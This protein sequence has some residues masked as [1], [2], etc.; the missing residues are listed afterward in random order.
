MKIKPQ[1]YAQL[2]VEGLNSDSDI[3]KIAENLWHTLQKNKQYRDLPKILELID[4]E[5]A[6][7]NNLT[8][9][10]VYSEKELAG[11]EI[12]EIKT[13]LINYSSSF[14]ETRVEKACPEHKSNGFST[15]SNHKYMIKN[16]IDQNSGGI[17][18]KID[19]RSID[20][21]TTGKIEKLKSQLSNIT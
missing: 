21:S 7:Q 14:R 11:G 6:K 3:A 8:L 16:I 15:S 2:L 4:Q 13:K 1:I 9:A 10:K 12:E 18:V 17:I 19:D 20:R 5:Y